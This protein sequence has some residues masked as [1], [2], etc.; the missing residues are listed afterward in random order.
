MLRSIASVFVDHPA[1]VGESYAEHAGFAASFG[2]T[3]LL[4]GMAALVHAALPFLC[5]DTA[6]NAVL[7]LHRLIAARRAAARP[8]GA[9]SRDRQDGRDP[10]PA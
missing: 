9:V 2:A 7:R 10:I 4:A 6:G 8:A 1:S 5:R 3:L